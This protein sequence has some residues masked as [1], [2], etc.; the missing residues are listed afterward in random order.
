[1]G[2]RLEGRHAIVTGA[3][4][5]IG[6]AITRLFLAEGASVLA[7]DVAGEKLRAMYKLEPGLTPLVADLA[8]SG[9]TDEVIKTASG[10]W[11][12]LDVLVNNAGI[13]PV[14]PIAETTDE[15]W[16]RV[17][18]VNLNAMFRL[19]RAAI[20]LLQ[21]SKAPRIVNVGSIMSEFAGAGLGA[22]TASK[23]AVAGLTKTLATELGPLGIRANYLQ[24]GAIVT[25]ITRDA[26]AADAGFRDFWTRKSAAG[27][28]GQPIDVARVALFLASDDAEFVNGQGILV[29]GGAM[30]SP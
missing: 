14:A 12:G 3:A 26:F 11:G 5:G 25:G 24:P 20:P 2:S 6:E 15:L 19:C 8:A 10:L 30:Q 16:G 27:R 21:R 18:E 29:D 9:A 22:Y 13:A 1:M 7:V 17:L 28:L 4:D 23:H